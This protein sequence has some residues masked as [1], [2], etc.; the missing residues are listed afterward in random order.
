MQLI[1]S[2]TETYVERDRGKVKRQTE[3][4]RREARDLD[5]V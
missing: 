3:A 2:V 1:D 4:E 5:K